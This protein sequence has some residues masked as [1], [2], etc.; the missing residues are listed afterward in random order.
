[1]RKETVL[2]RDLLAL[3]SG[4]RDDADIIKIICGV[5]RCGKS[6]LMSQYIDLLKDSGVPESNIVYL[7]L[8]SDA[9]SDLRDR[10]ELMEAVKE[11]M[12]EGMN[13][14]LIDEIQNVNE[15][16]I[17]VNAMRVSGNMDV[18][19]TGSNSNL[20]SSE[21]S[22]HLTGRYV[23]LEVFPLSFR[24]YLDLNGENEDLYEMFERYLQYGA[25]PMID[26]F[27]SEKR[28]KIRLT[29]LFSSIVYKDILM[30]ENIRDAAELEKIVKFMMFNI[31]NPLS[32]NK[33]A[34]SL[35][36]NPKTAGRYLWLLEEAYIF[37][38]A[39]RFDIK[40]TSLNP[41]P[42]YYS[43]DTGLRNMP[44]EYSNEDYGRQM[45]NIVYLELK[46]RGHTVKVERYGDKEV[47]FS[48]K[49]L[50]GY[51]YYQVT[52]SMMNESVKE[53][54]L[55]SLRSIDNNYPKVV[56][57][58]DRLKADFK[59]GIKHINI[60]DWLLDDKEELIKNF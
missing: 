51:V 57:S 24:E 34:N 58:A 37:Y 16:E 44:L 50:K 25:F 7:N 29:D 5:R 8:E 9:Q 28:I 45:E 6:T 3:L 12:G 55:G 32:V 11:R 38:R 60:I 13:Y 43:V 26:P 20:L 33:I 52:T 21:L 19:I 54:E 17:A 53:R 40:K 10:R 27:E 59:G 14:V 4:F 22:T 18:Y 48:V 46:R 2:R 47:D 56:I 41:N 23:S 1:M 15:W 42:K 35:G 39:D 30:R 31:G 36:I 49:T